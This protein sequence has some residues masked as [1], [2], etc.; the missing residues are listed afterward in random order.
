MR[1]WC[2]R[3]R[4]PN[5]SGYRLDAYVARSAARRRPRQTANGGEPEPPGG[6]LAGMGTA[7]EILLGIGGTAAALLA[8]LVPLIR[9]QGTNLRREIKDQG[10]NLRREIEGQGAS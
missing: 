8:V 6:K 1:T 4:W 7:L 2:A 10:T 9:S 5:S 3:P